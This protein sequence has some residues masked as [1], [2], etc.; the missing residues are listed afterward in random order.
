MIL[1]E[2][3]FFR[4]TRMT[5]QVKPQ[6][7]IPVSTYYQ[8]AFESLF[9]PKSDSGARNARDRQS[10]RQTWRQDGYTRED[11]ILRYSYQYFYFVL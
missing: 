2:R 1:Q 9:V 10:K 4:G 3:T 5:L 6:A 8:E 11:I 7:S